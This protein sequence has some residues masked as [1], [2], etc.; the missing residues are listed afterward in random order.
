MD[1]SI[2]KFKYGVSPI[3]EQNESNYDET[4]Q[5]VISKDPAPDLSVL[6]DELLVAMM[7]KYGMKKQSRKHMVKLLTEIWE[8]ETYHK[9]PDCTANA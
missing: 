3:T 9:M 1:K 6:S 5:K 2:I 4:A 8:Y 7:N